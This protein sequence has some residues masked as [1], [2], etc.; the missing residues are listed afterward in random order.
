MNTYKQ[1]AEETLRYKQILIDGILEF[2]T[3]NLF[4]AENLGSKSIRT[5]ERIY[6]NID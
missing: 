1:R 3:R 6:D 2:Q 4:T 5:L